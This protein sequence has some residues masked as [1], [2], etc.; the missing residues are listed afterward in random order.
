LFDDIRKNADL[1]I[2]RD[3]DGKHNKHNKQDQPHKI[4]EREI[5]RRPLSG[6]KH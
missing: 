4:I 2:I 6:N 3:R 1:E 5:N